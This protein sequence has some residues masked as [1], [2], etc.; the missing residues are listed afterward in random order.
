LSKNHLLACSAVALVLLP[1]A[2]LSAVAFSTGPIPR[3]TIN[4][5][6]VDAISKQSSTISTSDK[7]P[8]VEAWFKTHLPKG[9]TETTTT[10]G[11]H[12]FYLPV[13]ATV[14]VERE[15]SG[16]NIGLSWPAR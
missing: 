5:T 16:S 9:T 13:G 7:P 8:V 14:D 12:I 11:A 1:I 3:Y 10:D 15:G 4:V 6:S 2:A